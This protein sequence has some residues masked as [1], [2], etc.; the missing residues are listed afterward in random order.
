[1]E[2]IKKNVPLSVGERVWISS[3]PRFYKGEATIHE[4]EVVESNT[5]SAYVVE[6]GDLA[7][8]K[9]SRMRIEQKSKRVVVSVSMGYAYRFWRTKESF[10][11]Q[12]A[13]AEELVEMRKQAQVKLAAMNYNEL[14]A[15]LAE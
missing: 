8:E 6:V 9:P 12:Q 7:K 1:M 15:F 3:E 14:K 2:A 10:E 11:Q 4:Y 13:R 5:S